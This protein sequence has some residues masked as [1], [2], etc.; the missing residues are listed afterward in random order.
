MSG[1]S[2]LV[3]FGSCLIWTHR[4]L[5]SDS[6]R[7]LRHR[8]W[9]HMMAGS[10]PSSQNRDPYEDRRNYPRVTVA[11]PA[12]LQANGKRHAVQ[13]LDLSSGGAKLTCPADLPVGTPVILDCGTLGRAA[14]VRWQN[15]ELMGLSF[16]A[17]LDMREISALIARSTALGAWRKERE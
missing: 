4:H 1:S 11:L 15:G 7:V 10:V 13:L 17:E 2:A 12:F 16:E 8:D 3:T 5:L 6:T 9:R 14:L